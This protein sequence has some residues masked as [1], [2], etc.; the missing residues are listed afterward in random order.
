MAIFPQVQNIK[1]QY[2]Y[3]PTPIDNVKMA[4]PEKGNAFMRDAWGGVRFTATM[5]FLLTHSYAMILWQWYEL[6]RLL[7]FTFFDFAETDQELV[8]G[9]GTGALTT[10]TIPGKGAADYATYAFFFKDKT[11][12]AITVPGPGAIAVLTGT[13]A[14]GEDQVVFSAPAI[15]PANT[16]VYVQATKFRR[17]YTCEFAERARRRAIGHRRWLISMRIHERFPLGS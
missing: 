7:A 9:S 13:G 16:W 10:F 3:D 1:P 14:L 17:R 2:G 11:T 6:N 4:N 15:P 5:E 8:I 12:S